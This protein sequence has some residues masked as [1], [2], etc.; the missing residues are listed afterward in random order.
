MRRGG[1]VT[2]RRVSAI[3]SQS[4][5]CMPNHVHSFHL[6]PL[7]PLNRRSHIVVLELSTLAP[8]RF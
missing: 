2:S 5:W 3:T 4:S 6:F 1:G 7:A 8:P